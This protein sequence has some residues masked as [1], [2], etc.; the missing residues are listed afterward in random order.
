MYREIN[1]Y[2]C[3]C[4]VIWCI[5][6]VGVV[7]ISIM[8][9]CNY[10]KC[11]IWYIIRRRLPKSGSILTK[12][13]YEY[14]KYKFKIFQMLDHDS[15]SPFLFASYLRYKK[16]YSSFSLWNVKLA[17]KGIKAFLNSE[18]HCFSVIYKNE[19]QHIISHLKNS[20]YNSLY[21]CLKMYYFQLYF[22][23]SLNIGRF[24]KQPYFWTP[25]LLLLPLNWPFI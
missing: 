17:R 14:S 1:S 18:F 23:L 16:M 11:Y 22:G 5:K 3:F 9:L 6:D 19:Q 13:Q 15:I 4:C 25:S 10:Q 8:Q 24:G 12:K 21:I 2:I 20:I 7:S